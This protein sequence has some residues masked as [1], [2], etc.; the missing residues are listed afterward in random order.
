MHSPEV[1]KS[2]L[3]D[4]DVTPLDR[5]EF[6]AANRTSRERLRAEAER[7]ASRNRVAGDVA[8]DAGDSDAGDSDEGD[9]AAGSDES[10]GVQVTEVDGAAG[11]DGPDEGNGA[12]ADPGRVP[13]RVEGTS[14]FSRT[15]MREQGETTDGPARWPLIVVSVIAVVLAIATGVLSYAAATRDEGPA[16]IADADRAEV[17]ESAREYAATLATYAGG[18][19]DDLDRRIRDV[20]T[21]EFAQQYIESSQD[22]R[23]GTDT[24]G[25]SSAAVAEY[26][27]IE[28]MTANEAVVLVT[29]DQ[30]L[31][32]PDLAEEAPEGIPY[33]SRAKVTLVLEDGRWLLSGF[34]MV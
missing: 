21:P 17:M 18:E 20:S 29:L 22:A 30:T 32:A 6:L 15:S 34:S 24:A 8:V 13:G 5:D 26:A 19:Y 11:A 1:G 28:S 12:P 14:R 7:K 10:D 2:A 27:G 4:G 31:T 33:Q 23:E 25:A 9:S 3:R 16:P